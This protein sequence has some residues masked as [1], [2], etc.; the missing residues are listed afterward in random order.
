MKLLVTTFFAF[1]TAT[2]VAA[3]ACDPFPRSNFIGDFSHDQV[4]EYVDQAHGGDWDPYLGLL[5]QNL[6]S[7]R[8]EATR[9]GA[10]VLKVRGETV[11]VSAAE[12]SRFI[13]VSEQFRNVV[14]CLANVQKAQELNQFETAAGSADT[15][16]GGTASVQTVAARTGSSIDLG[17]QGGADLNVR[18]TPQCIDGD[19]VF[20]VV[21]EGAPWPDTGMFTMFRMDGPN[22]QMIGARRLTLGTSDV[23]E[24]TI[25]KSQNRT[26]HVGISI[27]P[28]W[29]SRA[30]QIDAD[31]RCN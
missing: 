25:S 2:S 30:F 17:P 13:Y 19:I 21:N 14:A 15:L 12:L 18:I 10:A 16:L 11:Q 6:R 22:R 26:G 23:R 9:S 1:L 7:L 8:N 24:F 4:A 5:D 27:D 28:S 20:R 31:A 3:A 29:Y